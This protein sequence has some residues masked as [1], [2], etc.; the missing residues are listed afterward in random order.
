M[1]FLVKCE[2]KCTLLAFIDCELGDL[3]DVTDD[4]KEENSTQTDT[5]KQAS[6]QYIVNV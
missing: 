4:L 6:S 3:K 5:L 1:C 2:F